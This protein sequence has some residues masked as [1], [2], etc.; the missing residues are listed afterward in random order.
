MELPR[1]QQ[2]KHNTEEI[3]LYTAKLKLTKKNLHNKTDTI[4]ALIQRK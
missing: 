1:P 4:R 3:G 2:A